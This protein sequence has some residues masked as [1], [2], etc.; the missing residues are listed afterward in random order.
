MWAA[1]IHGDD[2]Y[3]PMAQ[4]ERADLDPEQGYDR[5]FDWQ[6]LR[7][8]ILVPLAAGVGKRGTNATTGKR[9]RWRPMRSTWCP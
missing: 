8:E 3:R 1:V 2:F 6:R 4:I 7:E 9:V 5:Y